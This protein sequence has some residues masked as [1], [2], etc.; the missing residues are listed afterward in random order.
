M[1]A[2]IL[3]GGLGTRLYPVS[4][5]VPKCMVEI[6]NLPFMDYL[7][8]GLSI[9]GI[10][11]IVLCVGYKKDY[12]M[13]YF[14]DGAEHDVNITYSIEE[15]PLGTAGAIKNASKL[16]NEEFLLLNGDTFINY[17]FKKLSDNFEICNKVGIMLVYDNHCHKV[18]LNNV[19]LDG[20][21]ILSYMTYKTSYLNGVDTGVGIYSKKLLDYIPEGQSSLTDAYKKLIMDR[22]LCGLMTSKRY[23]DIGT[24]E[25]LKI[26]GDN[27][28]QKQF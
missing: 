2:V 17:P 23:Y 1:Q 20:T 28:C 5:E 26:F 19:L 11:D 24:P 13:N 4:K 10:E 18:A 25:R 12:V 7:I 9:Q 15:E 21:L 22:Q 3:C 27:I 16:L 8:S 14:R 6:N